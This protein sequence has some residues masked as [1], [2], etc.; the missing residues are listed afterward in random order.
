MCLWKKSEYVLNSWLEKLYK[1]SYAFRV[2][3]VEHWDRRFESW[4]GMMYSF[5]VQMSARN[6]SF[7]GVMTQ[8]M[9][10]GSNPWYLKKKLAYQ[11][12]CLL[13][14]CLHFRNDPVVRGSLL[15]PRRARVLFVNFGEWSWTNGSFLWLRSAEIT[16]ETLKCD[17]R[18]WIVRTTHVARA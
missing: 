14:P 7:R 3:P 16:G 11:I 17:K 12:Y 2:V 5:P 6:S 13:R 9:A 4:T 15:L 8:N 1:S 18:S 10:F